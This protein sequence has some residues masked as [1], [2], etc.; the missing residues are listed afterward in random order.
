[1][2]RR[3]NPADRE[4][5]LI[6]IGCTGEGSHPR[7]V[8]DT[9]RVSFVEDLVIVN[10]NQG[11]GKLQEPATAEPG[12]ADY[13]D[14]LETGRDY[15]TWQYRCPDCGVTL[16]IRADREGDFFRPFAE[17]KFEFIDV[18]TAAHVGG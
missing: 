10:H 18:S 8:F 2:S 14:R 13:L 12:T 11:R 1:M 15:L 9:V 4:E 17:Q 16:P 5:G 6:R 3:R 7:R